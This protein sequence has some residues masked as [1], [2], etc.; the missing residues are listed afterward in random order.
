MFD[1]GFDGGKRPDGNALVT[2]S[3][4]WME[5]ED[6]EQRDLESVKIVGDS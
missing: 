2:V 1:K 6:E 3:K 4:D 5:P